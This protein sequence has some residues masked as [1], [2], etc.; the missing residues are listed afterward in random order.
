M[1]KLGMVLEKKMS[2]GEYLEFNQ[3][4]FILKLNITNNSKKNI[5]IY[6]Q[7]IIKLLITS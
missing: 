3:L 2:K 7:I 4:K 1:G 6:E 5:T